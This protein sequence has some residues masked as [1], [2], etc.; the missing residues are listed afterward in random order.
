MS[1]QKYRIGD[2]FVFKLEDGSD[3]NGFGRVVGLDKPS[4]LVELYEPMDINNIQITDAVKVLF[5][6]WCTDTGITRGIWRIVGNFAIPTDHSPPKFY[7]SQAL[8]D[9]FFLI[10]GQETVE[11]T[12]EQIGDAQPYGIFGHGAVRI[13][14]EHDL[15]KK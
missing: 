7:K 15:S 10:D 2:L 5:T 13:K 1:R 9:K 3:R 14:Y 8:T 4:I 11:I 6:V 12:K